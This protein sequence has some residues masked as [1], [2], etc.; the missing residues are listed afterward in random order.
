MFSQDIF[1]KKMQQL[2]QTCLP[3]NEGLR[4][5]DHLILYYWLLLF[6]R[7]LLAHANHLLIT[8][9]YNIYHAL[10]RNNISQVIK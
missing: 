4:A 2:H 7:I 1:L 9:T 6:S 3:V 10:R 5:N 8:F